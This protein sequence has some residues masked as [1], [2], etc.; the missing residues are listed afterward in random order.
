M[1][2]ASL[3]F[4]P[5]RVSRFSFQ[6][7]TS[8]KQRYACI[9]TLLFTFGLAGVAA[10]Q[11][12][13]VT[14]LHT[15]EST[16]D[17]ASPYLASLV[18]DAEGNLYGTAQVGGDYNCMT[19]GLWPG[20]GVVFKLD[21]S[22][23]ETVL[24]T[25]TGGADGALPSGGLLRDAMG[26]L[27]G[28]TQFGGDLNCFDSSGCGTVF[29]LN[30]AGKETVLHS[31]AG[32]TDD[33]SLPFGNLIRDAAGN[34]Y[35][36]TVSGGAGGVGIIFKLDTTGKE[37]VLHAF[38]G[39]DGANPSSGLVRDAAGNLY[40]TTQFGGK[41]DCP[42]GGGCGVVFKLDQ[43]GNETVLHSFTGGPDGGQPMSGLVRDAAGN[44]YGTTFLGGDPSC[45]QSSP[46]GCGTVFRVDAA[47]NET[48]LYRF[49]GYTGGA[50][51]LGNLI[52]DAA[53]HIWGT[54]SD[55]GAFGNGTVFR[56]SPDGTEIVLHN[57]DGGGPEGAAPLGGVIRD[58][59]GNFYGT[60][61]AGG[62][63]SCHDVNGC[64]TV[65][66]IATVSK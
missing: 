6:R 12:H 21:S 43:V 47:G 25:F 44:L 9:I 42:F 5:N 66:K 65:F 52:R 54:T 28:T 20:C 11:A 34:L 3:S 15:F 2:S 38:A 22:G 31:F 30:K 59:A 50:N 55:G 19:G 40:G 8:S 39:E 53:G 4:T 1:R 17:G 26:S 33:G 64:G 29:R 13:K 58:A 32:G 60:T 56:L 61:S 48:T 7:K 41:S 14:V 27:Y 36:T 63:N 16:P 24:Y 62:D 23:T 10:A 51:P 45:P 49:A 37:T 18:K 57:F 46:F 35:G